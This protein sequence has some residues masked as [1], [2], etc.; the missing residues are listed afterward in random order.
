MKLD[1]RVVARKNQW[2]VALPA[3]LRRHLSLVPVALV[4]WHIGRKGLATLTVSGHLRGG[5][6]RGE[7]D[8]PACSKY[9][10]EL[11]RLRHELRE[12]DAALPGQYWRQGYMRALGDVGSV[13]AEVKLALVLLKQLLQESRERQQHESRSSVQR[14]PRRRAVQTM[15]APILSP[16]EELGGADTS[17]GEAPQVSHSET[18]PQGR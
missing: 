12:G 16:P 4:W 9:R 7:E 2:L 1:R 15:P 5:K 11:E 3:E 6:P 14:P 13:H 17:G 8:C 10:A 18:T